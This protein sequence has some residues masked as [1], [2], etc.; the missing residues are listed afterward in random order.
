[1]LEKRGIAVSEEVRDRILGCK[2][3]A[4]LRM[5]FRRAVTVEH[6]ENLFDED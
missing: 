1:M 4:Q 2:D 6:V 5:W 3:S